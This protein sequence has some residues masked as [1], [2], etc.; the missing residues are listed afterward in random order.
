MRALGPALAFALG[1]YVSLRG[2]A[3]LYRLV[4]LWYALP[5]AWA[6]VARPIAFWIGLAVV[7]AVLLPPGPRRAYAWGL[8]AFAVFY[9][10]L[11][12]VREPLLRLAAARIRRLS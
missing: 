4:D 8:G 3:A 6:A 11:Y 12:V 10:S 5:R 1:V 9:V 7:L 2:I